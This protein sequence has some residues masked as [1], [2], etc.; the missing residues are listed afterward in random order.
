MFLESTINI[1]DFFVLRENIIYIMLVIWTFLQR[2]IFFYLKWLFAASTLYK[3]YVI[4][5]VTPELCGNMRSIEIY[6]VI[7]Y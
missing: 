1:P 5:A 2:E 3:E 7:L 4:I 6:L